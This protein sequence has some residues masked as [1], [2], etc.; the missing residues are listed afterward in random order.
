MTGRAPAAIH[1]Q[2]LPG[3]RCPMTSR[4][5]R[6]SPPSSARR[7]I[8]LWRTEKLPAGG[9][10]TRGN[11]PPPP[12]G[13][14]PQKK[15]SP[16]HRP[17]EYCGPPCLPGGVRG[18]HQT[19]RLS[20]RSHPGLFTSLARQRSRLGDPLHLHD[21]QPAGVVQRRATPGLQKAPHR[22]CDVCRSGRRGAP[23]GTRLSYPLECLVE[24]GYS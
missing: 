19:T 9:T 10:E 6:S 22:Q 18:R 16:A 15:P 17:G 2:C 8:H 21:P 12:A 13:G 14:A 4:V 3:W 11:P 1:W 7:A 24:T 20:R 5:R 23:E